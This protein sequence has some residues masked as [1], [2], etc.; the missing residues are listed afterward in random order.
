MKN[1]HIKYGDKKSWGLRP[2]IKIQC[3]RT[4]YIDLP[5]HFSLKTNSLVLTTWSMSTAQQPLITWVNILQPH[6]RDVGLQ[7][8]ILNES[9]EWP[10]GPIGKYWVCQNPIVKL[11]QHFTSKSQLYSSILWY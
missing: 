8:Q 9:Y 4:S 6:W 7:P 5:Y 11:T 1:P 3:M 2:L 10:W